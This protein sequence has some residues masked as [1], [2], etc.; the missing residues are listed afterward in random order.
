M[1][2]YGRERCGQVIP[3][4]DPLF[5]FV[6]IPVLIGESDASAQ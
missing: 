3:M 1:A 4:G 6:R 5:D 2:C